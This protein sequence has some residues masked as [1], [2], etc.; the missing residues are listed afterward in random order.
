MQDIKLRPIAAWN[1]RAILAHFPDAKTRIENGRTHD[2]YV[3][4]IGSISLRIEWRLK[5]KPAD[6]YIFTKNGVTINDELLIINEPQ[7]SHLGR[8]H[9][10]EQGLTLDQVVTFPGLP[11]LPSIQFPVPGGLW[12]DQVSDYILG[13]PETIKLSELVQ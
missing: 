6:G 12:R 8:L 2:V 7:A 9:K 10:I 11:S 3:E 4:M 13:S 5:R 1:I